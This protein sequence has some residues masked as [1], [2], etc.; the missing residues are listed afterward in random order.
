MRRALFSDYIEPKPAPYTVRDDLKKDLAKVVRSIKKMDLPQFL[1][2]VR[3]QTEKMED[4]DLGKDSFR[5]LRMFPM[6]DVHE[7]DTRIERILFSAAQLLNKIQDLPNLE[8]EEMTADQIEELGSLLIKLAWCVGNLEL[9]ELMREAFDSNSRRKK[10][11][12]ILGNSANDKRRRFRVLICKKLVEEYAGQ[13]CTYQA[14]ADLA[15]TNRK[16]EH[17]FNQTAKDFGLKYDYFDLGKYL[18]RWRTQLESRD[19]LAT[20]LLDERKPS[21]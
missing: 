3:I 10:S 4:G 17:V 12:S 9:S 20:L 13:K 11:G 14:L 2:E 8:R 15:M 7:F 19:L 16:V 21:K 18:E 6:K 1:E 5:L